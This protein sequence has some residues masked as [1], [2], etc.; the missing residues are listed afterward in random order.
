LRTPFEVIVRERFEQLKKRFAF[1]VKIDYLLKH[2]KEPL[3]N[4]YDSYQSTDLSNKAGDFV[5]F[6]SAL[7]ST[8][9]L[10]HQLQ[11]FVSVRIDVDFVS[12]Q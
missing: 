2:T 11:K 8:D 4:F 1:V 10:K 5:F 7:I 6:E 9:S 12:H 3:I